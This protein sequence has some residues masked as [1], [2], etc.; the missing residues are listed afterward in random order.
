MRQMGHVDVS[1]CGHFADGCGCGCLKRKEKTKRKRKRKRKEKIKNE[2][3]I[4]SDVG[5][6]VWMGHVEALACRRADADGCKQ[7]RKEERGKNTDWRVPDVWMGVWTCGR[8][9]VWACR[10]ACSRVG[11]QMRM[12]GNK[13]KKKNTYWGVS[14]MQMGVR[15]GMWKQITV[16]KRKKKEKERKK[17]NSLVWACGCV[18]DGRACTCRWTWMAVNKQ[19]RKGEIKKEWNG[20]TAGGGHERAVQT[21]FEVFK[22]C[23]TRPNC[24]NTWKRMYDM[25]EHCL[26]SVWTAREAACDVRTAHHCTVGCL[27]T[28]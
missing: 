25:S 8:V 4:L 2:K 3:D 15:M 24:S 26:N 28:V 5:M 10:W 11:M 12:A 20:L 19:T 16:K 18:T 14:S 1:A 17:E 6:S 7:K 22:H 9:G 21:L 23:Q 13:K 27:N